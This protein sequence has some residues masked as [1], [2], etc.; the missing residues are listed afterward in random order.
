MS[1]PPVWPLFRRFTHRFNSQISRTGTSY[2]NK[3]NYPNRYIP[4][5]MESP[6]SPN[7]KPP[8]VTTTISISSTRDAATVVGSEASRMSDERMPSSPL[9]KNIEPTWIEL[10][11]AK[12]FRRGPK[13]SP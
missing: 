11:D 7:F 1:I 13:P 12:Q 2:N 4:A 10:E 3:Y 5:A 8:I 6:I 9:G